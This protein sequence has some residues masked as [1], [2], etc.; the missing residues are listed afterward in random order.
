MKVSEI[1]SSWVFITPIYNLKLH[2]AVSNELRI[3]RVTFINSEKMKRIKN[4]LGIDGSKLKLINEKLSA[5]PVRNLD[6]Y[7]GKYST[8]AVLRYNGKPKLLKS[9]CFDLIRDELNIIALSQLLFQKRRFTGSVGIAGE[10]EQSLAK[11]MFLDSS[12]PNFILGSELTHYPQSLDIDTIW[13]NFHKN[14]FFFKLLKILRDEIKVSQK[15]RETIRRASVL[16]GQSVNSN[17]KSNAFLWNMIG[18][19]SLLT[20]QGDSY[21]TE[22]QK[23]IES[24][25]GWIGIWNKESFASKIEEAYKI[26]C[27]YVHDGD[28]SRITKEILLFTDK[29]AFNI[30]LNLVIHPKIFSSKNSLI[31]FTDKYEAK[32]ILGLKRNLS[33]KLK[34]VNQHYTKDDLVN[35]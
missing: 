15:W 4:R 2:K 16:F 13:L 3:D 23:R 33:P 21:S 6:E 1:Q 29:V 12:N 30:L 10:N 28:N 11:H 18:I 7:F 9:K 35:V 20:R 31:K 27:E 19:E 24:L 32:K 17:D 5:G 34:F 26:R 25:L 22:L 14:L 8:F